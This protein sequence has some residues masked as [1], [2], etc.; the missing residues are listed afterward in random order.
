MHINMYI[1][2]IIFSFH[3]GYLAVL[4]CWMDAA[5]RGKLHGTAGGWCHADCGTMKHG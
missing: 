3:D 5:A 4:R 1:L 2:I